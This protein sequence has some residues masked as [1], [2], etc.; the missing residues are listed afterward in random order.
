MTEFTVGPVGSPPAH[1]ASDRPME[2]GDGVAGSAPPPS[3]DDFPTERMV[4]IWKEILQV[5]EIGEDDNFYDLGGR[6][7]AVIRL[8]MMIADEFDTEVPINEILEAPTLS[9]QIRLIVR[10]MGGAG[11]TGTG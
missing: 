1:H 8:V 10:S 6:S 7:V 3:T 11:A 9:E 4:A 5:G 2:Q